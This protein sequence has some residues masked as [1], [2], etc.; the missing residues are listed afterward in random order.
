[1]LHPVCH[2]FLVSGDVQ[3]LPLAGLQGLCPTSPFSLAFFLL[4]LQAGDLFDSNC[5]SAPDSFV[6]QCDVFKVIP[7]YVGKRE[8]LTIYCETE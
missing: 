8:C 2:G 6:S 5:H 1:M 7:L 3:L 4:S